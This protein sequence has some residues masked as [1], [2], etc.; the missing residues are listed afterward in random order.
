MTRGC[1]RAASG[2]SVHIATN[3]IIFS[4]AVCKDIITYLLYTKMHCEYGSY[5]FQCILYENCFIN[6]NHLSKLH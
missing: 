6:L 5:C 4:I 1:V 2:I 3:T